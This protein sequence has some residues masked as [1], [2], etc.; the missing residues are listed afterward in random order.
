[1]INVRAKNEYKEALAML[2]TAAK[3]LALAEE[4]LLQ[5]PKKVRQKIEETAEVGDAE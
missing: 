2:V 1:M 5:K 4:K 3:K